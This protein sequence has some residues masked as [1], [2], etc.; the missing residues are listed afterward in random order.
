MRASCDQEVLAQSSALVVV[1]DQLGNVDDGLTDKERARALAK[2][3]KVE[4]KER[5]K[6]EKKKERELDRE[7]KRK[8]AEERRQLSL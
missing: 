8:E 5:L 4:E 7:T 6:E 2:K 3:T 1:E